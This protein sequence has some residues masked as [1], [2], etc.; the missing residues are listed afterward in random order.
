MNN[1]EYV[2][3]GMDQAITDL[4]N[5]KNRAS[6]NFEEIKSTLRDELLAAGMSGTTADALLATFEKEVTE[7][8][9]NY[10]ENAEHFIRQNIDVK[11]V[12]DENS[13][14]N[15]NIASM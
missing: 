5:A 3:A 10:L 14:K 7:P 6:E 12:M 11:A 8:A 15:V 2:Q 1:F 9:A 13:A 4:T